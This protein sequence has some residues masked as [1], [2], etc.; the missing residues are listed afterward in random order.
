[1]SC[2]SIRCYFLGNL[3]IEW[4]ADGRPT[5]VN[6]IFLKFSHLFDFQFVRVYQYIFYSLGS[7]SQSAT[8]VG[9][10]YTVEAITIVIEINLVLCRVCLVDPFACFLIQLKDKVAER[11]FLVFPLQKIVVGRDAV[12]PDD[13][14]FRIYLFIILQLFVFFR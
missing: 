4:Q 11:L 10:T 7:T 6:T 5:I 13:M 2:S 1:M 3:G 12:F 9:S 8:L 14:V